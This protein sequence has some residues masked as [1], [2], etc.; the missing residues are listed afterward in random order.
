MTARSPT[1][2]KRL[3]S[4][5]DRC[6]NHH[7]QILGHDTLLLLPI[8]MQSR[9]SSTPGRKLAEYRLSLMRNP[10]TICMGAWGTVIWSCS[11]GSTLIQ[12]LLYNLYKHHRLRLLSTVP[13]NRSTSLDV[14][15]V[16]SFVISSVS[17]VW[18]ATVAQSTTSSPPT[19]HTNTLA[20][21][22]PA[23]TNW[24][25]PHMPCEYCISLDVLD[26]ID[27][28]FVTRRHSVDEP[29][30]GDSSASI[31]SFHSRQRQMEQGPVVPP[32]TLE[33]RRGL[34]RF[35]DRASLGLRM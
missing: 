3:G 27:A 35:G 22:R 23:S 11:R 34:P 32:P 31:V 14:S 10:A 25:R 8:N 1:S 6:G 17:P 24:S 18:L 26:V 13:R 4:S 33:R 15:P 16:I 2:S 21:D 12:A 5:S 29:E 9:L 28:K 7:D 20:N 30:R 19:V